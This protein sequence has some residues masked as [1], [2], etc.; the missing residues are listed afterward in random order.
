MG[1]YEQKLHIR[2]DD[3]GD[4]AKQTEALLL[5]GASLRKCRGYIHRKRVILLRE[6]CRQSVRGMRECQTRNST[7]SQKGNECM[8]QAEVS[9]SRST[10]G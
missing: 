5:Y 3:V 2:R 4:V 10:A 7:Q 9:R 1:A 6:I 8:V